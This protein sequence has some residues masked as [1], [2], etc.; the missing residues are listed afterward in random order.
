MRRQAE[1]RGEKGS[2]QVTAGWAAAVA[3]AD[4]EPRRSTDQPFLWSWLGVGLL[5]LSLVGAAFVVPTQAQSRSRGQKPL[6]LKNDPTMIGKRDINKGNLAFYSID[7]EVAIGRQLAAEIDQTSRL[8]TDTAVNEFVN[9]IGQNLV[10]HSDAKLPF[11][12][13]VIDEPEVNAF[14]LP[15]GFLYINRGLLEAAENEAEVAGVLAHEIAHVT[16]RHGIEQAS[17]GELLNYASIPLL[18][19][20]G[21]GGYILQQVAGI[22]VPLTFLKFSRG[23]E[24]EADRLGAQYMWATGYD[25]TALITFFEKLQRVEKSRPGAISKIFSTHPMTEDRIRDVQALI[26]Q[27]P[28]RG[29]YQLNSSEYAG[30]RSRLTALSAVSAGAGGPG[31]GADGRPTLRRRPAEATDQ[32]TTERQDGENGS[33]PEDSATPPTR[34]VLR[35]GGSEPIDSTRPPSA[36]EAPPS[37]RTSEPS[38]KSGSGTTGRPVLKRHPDSQ[39]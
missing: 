23:A 14:A 3:I 38:Q 7:R 33:A 11:T 29:E 6:D 4:V 26:R 37:P 22:A 21:W 13:K 28:D 36:E 10:L 34:P 9:R 19:L 32:P 35:R 16:A 1:R 20:G 30:I 17:K 12:I 27:F 18:F 25:P 5:W 15:G 8:V 24:R 31:E 39:E 2:R